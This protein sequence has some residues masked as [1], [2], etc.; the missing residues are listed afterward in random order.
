MFE[1]GKRLSFDEALYIYKEL[2]LYELGKLA[3]TEKEKKAEFKNSVFWNRNLH[4]NPTNICIG[5]CSF[6]SF[7]RTAKDS[8]AYLMTQEEIIN[9]AKL[10]SEAGAKEVHIV[11]GLNPRANLL[12]Y[13][14]AFTAIKNNFPELHIKALTAVE[15]DF[16]AKLEK[17]SYDEILSKLISAG[18]NSM[19][20]GG[21]EIFSKTVRTET[22]P[23]KLS[24]EKWLE[25]HGIA[26]ALGLKTNA[27]M[28]AGIGET[29]EDRIDHMLRLREQQDKTK[30]FQAFI[31]LSCHYERNEILNSGIEPITGIEQLKNIAIGRLLLDNFE[32]IKAYWVQMGHNLAQ[33]SLYFG[34]DDLDGTVID[35]RITNS[36]GGKKKGSEAEF[37]KNLIISAGFRPI[38]RNTTYSVI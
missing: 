18:L 30:G 15:I 29:I 14:N 33:I 3:F 2:P 11:G 4:I 34:A 35:E 17:A 10:G 1:S 8:D 24:P 21:A 5:T 25:I 38:E 12:Y 31:P 19:P 22:C 6:C 23:G 13:S 16:L 36:A 32:H 28:L 27:T 9:R 7:R 37:L 26:H 20:G